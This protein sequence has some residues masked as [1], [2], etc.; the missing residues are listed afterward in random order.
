M[1]KPIKVYN[2]RPIEGMWMD[3]STGSVLADILAEYDIIVDDRCEFAR[4]RDY[5]RHIKFFYRA[6]AG[7]VSLE[8]W[9]L[10]DI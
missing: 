6:T 3:A 5:E 7:L 10:F 8:L 2:F 9:Q 4:I 1:V